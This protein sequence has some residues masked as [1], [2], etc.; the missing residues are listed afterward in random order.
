MQKSIDY[1]V[2]CGKSE[3]SFN[4]RLNNHRKNMGNPSAIPACVPASL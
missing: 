3:T 4:I 2:E 1:S